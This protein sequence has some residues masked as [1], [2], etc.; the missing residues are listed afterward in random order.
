MDIH[1]IHSEKAKL[2]EQHGPWVSHNI[3]LADDCYT[4][5]PGYT[6]KGERAKRYLQT[7]ADIAR[8]PFKDL[9]ILDLACGE[10]CM[11]SNARFMEPTLS[12]SRADC[13]I[14]LKA[15]S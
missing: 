14:S 13:R 7:I 11:Q 5:R 15:S 6:G 9:R 8:R 12:V 3:R 4:I 2:V 1:R 10:G